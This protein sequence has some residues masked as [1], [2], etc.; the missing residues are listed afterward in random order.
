METVFRNPDTR[1]SFERRATPATFAMVERRY[2]ERR[3]ESERRQSSS[4]PAFMQP[5]LGLFAASGKS[6][7]VHVP[8][9]LILSLSSLAFLYLI[10]NFGSTPLDN[11][12]PQSSHKTGEVVIIDPSEAMTEDIVRSGYVVIETIDM[13]ALNIKVQHLRIPRGMSVT[14]SLND[15][16]H[17]YPG[18]EIDANTLLSPTDPS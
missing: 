7:Q 4:W 10:F 18:I 17:R 14:E 11:S 5:L 2:A 9:W 13:K 8:L 12:V 15:L 16:R 6:K 3:L 1:R